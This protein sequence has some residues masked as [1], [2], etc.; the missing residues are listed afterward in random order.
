MTMGGIQAKGGTRP[1]AVQRRDEVTLDLVIPVHDE[2]P[3]LPAL[4][5]AL[6]KTF[7]EPERSRLGITAVTCLFVDDGSGDR[8][9]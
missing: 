6:A 8:S 4:L 2:E 7:A 9:V 3:V 1:G 5:G